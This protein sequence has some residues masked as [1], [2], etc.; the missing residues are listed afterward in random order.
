MEAMLNGMAILE[1]A[2]ESDST[3]KNYGRVVTM[4]LV[5]NHTHFW[6]N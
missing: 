4:W 5:G 6:Y 3:C 1:S 2:S